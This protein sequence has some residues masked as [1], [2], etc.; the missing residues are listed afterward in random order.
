VL[1]RSMDTNTKIGLN[2]TISRSDTILASD[3]GEEFVMMNINSGTYFNL[4]EV[5]A[6]VWGMM[7]KEVTISD[8][9]DK[10]VSEYDIDPETCANEVIAF[11]EEMQSLGLAN[12]K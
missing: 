5:G 9:R 6:R 1:F 2:T 3:L 7:E 10:L 11:A 8:I 4:V 12:L